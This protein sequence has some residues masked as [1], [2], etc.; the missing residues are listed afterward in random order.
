MHVTRT[1]YTSVQGK[2]LPRRFQTKEDEF[3]GM[4]VARGAIELRTADGPWM[5]GGKASYFLISRRVEF[6]I[7]TPRPS[8]R[9]EEHT[10]ELQSLMR[11]SY[12]VSCLKKK[13]IK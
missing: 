11:T 6:D 3:V 7:R 13:N 2:D 4:F 10:S 12:A 8:E 9:S 5:K 1:S